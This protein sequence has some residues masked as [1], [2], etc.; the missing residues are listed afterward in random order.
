M[1]DVKR[2][3]HCGQIAF[4]HVDN[5]ANKMHSE[6]IDQINSVK[7]IYLTDSHKM[8]DQRLRFN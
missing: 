2:F 5:K 3:I 8:K 6:G 7:S 1:N 4:S